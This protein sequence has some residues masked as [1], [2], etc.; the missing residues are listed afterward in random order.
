M[1]RK[2]TLYKRI[3][4]PELHEKFT[5]EIIGPGKT[6]KKKHANSP[7]I[8]PTRE[9]MPIAVPSS[10]ADCLI[11]CHVMGNMNMT[12]HALTYNED[13]IANLK[14]LCE[15]HDL[16]LEV[17]DGPDVTVEEFEIAKDRTNR[18]GIF[19]MLIKTEPSV[20]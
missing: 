3:S 20:N 11:L 9:M 1:K 10:E 7:E 13:M 2:L 18:T 16:E 5:A 6:A 8:G 15:L 12:A 14:P 17:V 19:F 4:S